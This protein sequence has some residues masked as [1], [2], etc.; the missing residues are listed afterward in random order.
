MSSIKPRLHPIAQFTIN[1]L[2]FINKDHQATQPL[3]EFANEKN[4]TELYRWMVTVRILDTKAIHLQRTGK[5]GT[6]PSSCGQEA[7]SVG[8]GYALGSDDIY[9]PAYRDQGVLLQRNVSAEEILA[10]WGGDER[11]NCFLHNTQ[12]LPTCVTVGGQCLHAA[13]VAVAIKYRKQNRSVVTLVGDGGT[14]KGD[15]YEAINLA[16]VWQLPL[17]I[18]INNNQWAISVP[19][20]RQTAAQTLAQKAIAG[21]IECLQVDGN[22]VIAVSYAVS[23]GIKKA[24]AGQGGSVIEAVTYRLADHTTADDATRYRTKEE[25]EAAWQG[26]PIARLAQYMTDQGWW[27]NTKDQQLHA[28]CTDLIDKEIERYLARSKAPVTDIFDFLYAHLPDT[29]VDQREQLLI[30]T[31]MMKRN[32]SRSN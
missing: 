32:H 1:H 20:K 29:L 26:E 18:V 2:C 11:G 28:Q 14:S 19:R 16:G 25:L 15:F 7:V 27:D 9:C 21:G 13:G 10:Y 22:D 6:Y 5:L 23:E 24:R 8:L 3:P 30:E 4:L 31:E 12:D 17:V